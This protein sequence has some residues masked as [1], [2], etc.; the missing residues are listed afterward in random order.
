MTTYKIPKTLCSKLDAIAMRFWLGV[1][2][3][4]KHFIAWKSWDHLCKHQEAGE[5]GFKRFSDINSWLLSKLGWKMEKREDC[6]WV[7]Q[8]R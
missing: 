7:N 4:Q 6:M 5:L 3:N 1:K 8:L 2:A